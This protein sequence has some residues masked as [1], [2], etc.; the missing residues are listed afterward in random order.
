MIEDKIGPKPY[1]GIKINYDN[2]DRLDKFS[3]D[4]LKDRYFTG[5]ETHAQE[6]FARA[7][8]F[9][10]TFKGVT[11]FELAQRLYQ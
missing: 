4:T 3:L 8:T 9:G 1:L 5:E 10:A 7:A 2:E 11:D 6:A